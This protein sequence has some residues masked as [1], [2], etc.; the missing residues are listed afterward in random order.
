ME[1]LKLGMGLLIIIQDIEREEREE[2][3]KL[4]GR[5]KK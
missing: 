4:K 1:I 2:G 5:R 3:K